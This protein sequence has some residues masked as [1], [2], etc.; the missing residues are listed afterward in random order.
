MATWPSGKAGACKALIPQFE[1]GCRLFYLFLYYLLVFNID[2][3]R[4]YV[5]NLYMIKK[6]WLL[7]LLLILFIGVRADA[8]TL[9]FNGFIADE[10][11]LL[12]PQVENDLNMT[13]WDLQKKSGADLVVVTLPSLNGKTVEEVAIDIGR[14]YKL[15]AKG[16]NNGVVFLTAPTERK[17]RI[18]LGTGIE[19]ILN[20]AENI[21]DDDILPYYKK[22]D[23]QSGIQRGTY[24]LADTIAQ[25]EGVQI[26]KQGKCPDRTTNSSRKNSGENCPWWLYPI[27][28]LL[29]IFSP[30]RGRRFNSG[31]FGGFGGGGGFGGCGCSGS[32]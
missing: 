32:W 15:G 31:S 20:S 8:I 23:Y 29:A 6:C 3:N 25:A 9:N 21:R 10:A 13:L 18:E 5:Y 16:K 28:V 11:D 30:N 4:I 24:L 17:M 12:S 7:G 14:S 27:A 19:Q 22:E 2:I 26:T 1:S